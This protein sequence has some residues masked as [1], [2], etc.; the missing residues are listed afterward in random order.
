MT[1]TAAPYGLKLPR[2][3]IFSM[4]RSTSVGSSPIKASLKCSTHGF[5]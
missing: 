4:T 3:R 2:W 1:L 5:R